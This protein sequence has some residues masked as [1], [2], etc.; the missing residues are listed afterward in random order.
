[1]ATQG[2]KDFICR[3]LK[4]TRLEISTNLGL[5]IVYNV[6]IFFII[7]FFLT[8]RVGGSVHTGTRAWFDKFP[9]DGIACNHRASS[10]CELSEATLDRGQILT[11][12]QCIDES[13]HGVSGSLLVAMFS[14]KQQVPMKQKCGRWVSPHLTFWCS[15][16]TWT[17]NNVLS[18]CWYI[19]GRWR[20]HARLFTLSRFR[21]ARD[22]LLWCGARG[23][24]AHLW[25]WGYC[26]S[27]ACV[28]PPVCLSGTWSLSADIL[29]EFS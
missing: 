4:S 27:T 8:G 26:R 13:T 14:W 16:I 29:K 6:H 9:P 10:V 3:R 11:Q 12:Y 1:M 22:Y 21:Y 18:T 25:F 5:R 17:V 7:H 19:G 15:C 24:K 23:C 20:M 28:C 2:H